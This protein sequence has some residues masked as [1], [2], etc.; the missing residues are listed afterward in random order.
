MRN[1]RRPVP[2][3]APW[4]L[5]VVAAASA[6]RWWRVSS[7]TADRNPLRAMHAM[8]MTVVAVYPPEDINAA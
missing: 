4:A 5:A 3:V 1:M 7:R 6:W 2:A 8:P